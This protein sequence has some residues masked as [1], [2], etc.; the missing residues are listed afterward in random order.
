MYLKYLFHIKFVVRE[1]I[2]IERPSKLMVPLPV[3]GTGCPVL[4]NFG[5]RHMLSSILHLI[6]FASA[7]LVVSLVSLLY[8]IHCIVFAVKNVLYPS[9]KLSYTFCTSALLRNKA[10]STYFVIFSFENDDGLKA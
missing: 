7:I 3:I 6:C 1:M 9:F 4:L 8:L 5:R 10:S 2:Q